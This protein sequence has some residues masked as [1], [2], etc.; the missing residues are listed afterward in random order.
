MTYNCPKTQFITRHNFKALYKDSGKA[1]AVVELH[2]SSSHGNR[3]YVP[4]G[5]AASG[6]S[7]RQDRS[8][9]SCCFRFP[10]SPQRAG[11]QTGKARGPYKM[12]TYIWHNQ[13]CAKTSKVSDD[14]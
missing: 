3:R 12:N 14:A 1:K 2:P 5:G 13:G 8:H 4:A 9:A 10:R 7:G 11:F 6:L